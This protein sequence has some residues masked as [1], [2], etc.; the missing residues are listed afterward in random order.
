MKSFKCIFAAVFLFAVILGCASGSFSEAMI[1]IDDIAIPTN[2]IGSGGGTVES[3]DYLMNSVSGQSTPIGTSEVTIGATAYSIHQGYIYTLTGVTI[4]TTG[5][6]T[7]EWVMMNGLHFRD[8]DIISSKAEMK[9]RLLDEQGI[10]TIE[11]FV[12]TSP[13]P[14]LFEL[15][16]LD[17]PGTTFEGT[18]KGKITVAINEVG[19]H[20]LH[21][22]ARDGMGNDK[23]LDMAARI[24]GGKVSVIG[25]TY[26]Y[27]NPFSPMG[28]GT[29]NIQYTLSTDATITFILYDIT[30][31][32]VKRMKFGAGAQGGRGGTNQVSWNGQSMGGEVVGNGMYLYKII[33]GTTVIGSGKI[34][35]FE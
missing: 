6:P 22:H 34:V 14:I 20:M 28:G 27:P 15:D 11:L 24:L 25:T 19:T 23:Y 17:L 32:E 21:F 1:S 10:A 29:T 18:W 30:G 5:A 13:T 35:I 16:P 33:S 31:H 9:V 8:G 26:N 12:D 3:T 4:A 2:V 7:I